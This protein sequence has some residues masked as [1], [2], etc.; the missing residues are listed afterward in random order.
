MGSAGSFASSVAF[1]W[2]LTVTGS[3]KMYFFA[4]AF[5]NALAVAGWWRIGYV[6]CKE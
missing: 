1:P 2:L 3:I 5:L 6:S 4:A